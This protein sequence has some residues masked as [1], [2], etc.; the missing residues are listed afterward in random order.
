[1]V[2]NFDGLPYIF[3][4]SW[5]LRAYEIRVLSDYSCLFYAKCKLRA[6][7]RVH[8]SCQEATPEQD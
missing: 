4:R 5:Y 2:R 8:C 7:E 6:E 1:M 3:E